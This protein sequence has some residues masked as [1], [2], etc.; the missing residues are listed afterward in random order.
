MDFYAKAIERDGYTVIP[1]V[2]DAET[3]QNIL[4]DLERVRVETNETESRR[5]GKAFGIEKPVERITF[6]SRACE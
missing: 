5:A 2:I 1:D 3:I 6:G 4:E